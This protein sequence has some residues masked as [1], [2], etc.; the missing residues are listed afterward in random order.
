MAL[1][2]GPVGSR[3]LGAAGLLAGARFLLS[4]EALQEAGPWPL[5]ALGREGEAIEQVRGWLAC[6]KAQ[7]CV[8]PRMATGMGY[9]R[10][11]SS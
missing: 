1:G 4:L 3:N 9:G 7:G 10:N 8:N 11:W 2:Q 5:S 6:Q